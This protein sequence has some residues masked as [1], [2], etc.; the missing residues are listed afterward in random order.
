MATRV[1]SLYF[2]LS[3]QVGTCT[4]SFCF[5]LCTTG[6]GHVNYTINNNS[7]QLFTEGV[8]LC[9]CITATVTLSYFESKHSILKALSHQTSHSVAKLLQVAFLQ[10]FYVKCAFYHS[11]KVWTF[12][13]GCFSAWWYVH[14][15]IQ[16]YMCK[17][18]SNAVKCIHCTEILDIIIMLVNV[19][20]RLAILGLWRMYLFCM[21]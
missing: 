9:H 18:G 21:P 16:N 14:W 13:F 15:S 19:C 7:G 11:P 10:F 8:L 17:C 6:N 2:F 20:V 4:H 12:Q 5:I 3:K 1:L